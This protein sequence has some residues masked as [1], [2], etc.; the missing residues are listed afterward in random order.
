[1]SAGRLVRIAAVVTPV[2]MAPAGVTLAVL[3]RRTG[4]HPAPGIL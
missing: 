1:M 4:S 2:A 3:H